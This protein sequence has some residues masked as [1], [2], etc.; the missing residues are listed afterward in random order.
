M[1]YP[2]Y[3]GNGAYCYANST[4]M[5]LSSIGEN[6]SPSLIEVLGGVG[7]GAYVLTDSNMTFLSN[8]SGLPDRG[9]SRA[10]NALGFKFEESAYDT[11]EYFPLKELQRLMDKGPVLL[12][13]LDM[14]FLMYDPSAGSHHGIDHFVVAFDY[15]EDSVCVH[16]PAEFPNVWIKNEDLQ[17]AWSADSISY[18]RGHFRYWTN[19]SRINT[20]S[21]KELY[22]IV[23]NTL[24]E[25]YTEGEK[26]AKLKNKLIDEEAI[27]FLSKNIK[28]GN[29]NDDNYGLLT[30]F[31]FPVSA[32]RANDFYYFLKGFNKELAEIKFEMSKLLGLVHT[33]TVGKDY[34]QAAE[35]LENYADLE[36]QFKT[37]VFGEEK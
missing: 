19:P 14:G 35:L 12:G 30:G 2:N 3:F 26:Y 7:I 13:P 33:R 20:P 29:L 6:I 15:N 22:E 32:K 37:K 8:Y 5:L 27:L 36:T 1:K 10:L 28:E 31:I 18:K 24:K 4:A 9:V 16:D 21:S 23:V 25:V 17:K 11:N 34:G